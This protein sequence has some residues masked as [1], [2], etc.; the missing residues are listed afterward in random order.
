MVGEDSVRE[1][2]RGAVPSEL[3]RFA[4]RCSCRTASSW[5]EVRARSYSIRNRRWAGSES[6]QGVLSEGMYTTMIEVCPA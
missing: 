5:R 1:L 4:Q 6:R 2:A 3:I